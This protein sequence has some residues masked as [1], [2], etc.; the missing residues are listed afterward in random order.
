LLKYVGGLSGQP[1]LNPAQTRLTRGLSESGWVQP[2]FKKNWIL[3]NLTRL[4]PVVSRVSSWVETHFDISSHKIEM[5]VLGR[6]FFPNQIKW[7]LANLKIFIMF[8]NK[9]LSESEEKDER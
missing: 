2:T 4:E 1:T 8:Q 3:L 5:N 9:L 6:V 7:V